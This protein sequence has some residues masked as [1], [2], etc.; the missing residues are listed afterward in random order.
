VEPARTEQRRV[1]NIRPVGGGHNDDAFVH[2]ETVHLDQQLV[3]GL[4][5]FVMTAAQA[6][7]ALAPDGVNLVDKNNTGGI[8]LRVLEQ[9]ANTR[10]AD[11]DEHLDEVG[12]A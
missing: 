2:T 7:T 9:V 5:A 6:G 12:T 1:K 10:S 3:E 11:T 8:L 4:L